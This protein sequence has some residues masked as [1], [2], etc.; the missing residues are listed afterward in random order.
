MVP[1]EGHALASVQTAE[2]SD[3]VVA[4]HS[5]NS[6]LVVDYTNDSFRVLLALE[7]SRSVSGVPLSELLR[8]HLSDAARRE[9]SDHVAAERPADIELVGADRIGHGLHL[10]LTPTP[11]KGYWLGSLTN[12][13]ALH[14]I[15]IHETALQRIRG[16][17]SALAPRVV[18]TGAQRRSSLS[19]NTLVAKILDASRSL[20]AIKDADGRYA[21]VNDRLTEFYGLS[22]DACVGRTAAE[23]GIGVP[24]AHQSD[25]NRYQPYVLRGVQLTDVTG[26]QRHFDIA[27]ETAASSDGA[28]YLIEVATETESDVLR[29]SVPP[30]LLAAIGAASVH[31]EVRPKLQVT[32]VD[33]A[34]GAIFGAPAGALAGGLE[35][36][37]AQVRDGGGEERLHRWQAQA[38][39]GE[40]FDEELPIVD[41]HG[42]HRWLRFVAQPSATT[43]NEYRGL[44]V[45][46]SAAK[47]AAS[48]EAEDEQRLELALV[49]GSLA[50]VDWD[51]ESGRIAPNAQLAKLLGLDGG[52]AVA[53][54][55]RLAEYEHPKDK[56]R[57]YSE[58]REHLQGGSPEFHCEYRLRTAL[59]QTLWV[60]ANGRVISRSADG[61]PLRY[62]G[63]LEDITEP[64]RAEQ[65]LEK[66]IAR[67]Q[68]VTRMSTELAREVRQLEG[69]IRQ[70]SHREQQRIG[71]DLHDGLGQELTGVSLML[72]TLEDASRRDVPQLSTRIRAVRDMV[73]QSIATTR[74]LAEGLSPVHSTAT[75]SRARS[76]SSPRRASCSMGSR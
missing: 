35:N 12:N 68:A 17:A 15:V 64:L 76:S 19:A 7:D 75:G 46:I 31:F 44:I 29:E 5:A 58:L 48:R 71:H 43:E 6:D 14:G 59:G 56:Q 67:S 42:G 11:I 54:T 18:A 23:L 53:T 62:V 70:I 13:A 38:E 28:P 49:N 26:R 27:Y 25:A 34:A 63:T 55:E 40:R 9:L 10:M 32:L 2:D 4:C 47:R 73:E 24:G 8:E 41:G 20:I 1:S 21:L 69:E 65:E 16:E 57:M 22:R 36:L 45:D 39:R 50:L 66:E 51:I 37:L 61:R 60:R 52:E 72:K 74:A 3:G 30:A 33:N